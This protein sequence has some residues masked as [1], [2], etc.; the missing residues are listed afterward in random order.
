MLC[1]V[2]NRSLC[3]GPLLPQLEAAC[4]GGADYLLIREKDLPPAERLALCRRAMQ[5]CGRYGTR[6]VVNGD[7]SCAMQIGAYG[8]QL[9]YAAF[10]QMKREQLPAGLAAGVSVHSRRR[11]RARRRTGRIACWPVMCLQPPAR[12]GL[13]RAGCRLSNRLVRKPGAYP[14]G[15]SAGSRRQ[16]AH[17]C[18]AAA[19]RWCA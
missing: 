5:F 3:K 18:W 11:P 15:Q 19:R 10:M 1:V 8:V 6:L 17:R 9:P 4:R 13:R 2:S 14:F 16:T 7:I 12:R